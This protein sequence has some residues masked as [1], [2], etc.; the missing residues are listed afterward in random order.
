MINNQKI[1]LKSGSFT[2]QIGFGCASLLQIPEYSDRQRLLDVA[3]DNGILHYDVARMYG[4]GFAESQLKP[5]IKRKNYKPTIASK[6]GTGFL[7]KSNSFSSKQT[8][9][10]KIFKK[11]PKIK[12]AAKKIYSYL[13]KKRKIFDV[14]TCSLSL[15]I[16]LYELGVDS[17]ELFFLHEPM[18]GD[19]IDENLYQT[20]N[21]FVKEG[22]INNFGFSG[23]EKDYHILKTSNKKLFENAIQM[24]SN[25]FNNPFLKSN[26]I[27]KNT[28][29]SNFGII[30][31]SY[32]YINN[33]FNIIP[34]LRNHWSEKLNLDLSISSNLI[35]VIL[36][37]FM[38][39]NPLNL[40]IFSTTN[41][42]NLNKI[43][44]NINNQPWQ[45][46]DILEFHKFWKSNNKN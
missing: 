16:S 22:K 35:S 31:N 41:Y 24:E 43:M 7:N 6:F 39:S 28:L 26:E 38:K 23:F 15:E 2:S 12:T 33:S 20:L 46:S 3:F 25:L 34:Q 21:K 27:P 17:I 37:S 4:L 30:R 19:L 42:Q 45:D 8:I 18:Y 40:V 36:G 44:K 29:T 10:R 5:F 9:F 14:K 11:I 32:N 1:N 13:P